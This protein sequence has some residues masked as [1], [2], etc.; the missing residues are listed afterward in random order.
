[1]E[2]ASWRGKPVYFEITGHWKRPQAI[3]SGSVIAFLVFMALL[4]GAG[5]MAWNNLRQGRCDRRGAARI[6][7]FAFLLAMGSRG[8]TAEHVASYWE[9]HVAL[10]G[11]GVAA[12]MAAMF[13]SLYIAIEPYVRRNWP[14]ALISWTRLQTGRHRRIGVVR[15]LRLVSGT[16]SGASLALLG[17]RHAHALRAQQRRMVCL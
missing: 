4:V 1:M 16:C 3:A 8:L 5:S 15:C 10:S 11:L 9:L 14:D 2:A 17:A 7:V 13:W 12:L 6:A